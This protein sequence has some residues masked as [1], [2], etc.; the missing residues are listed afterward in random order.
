MQRCVGPLARLGEN[1]L[2]AITARM[3]FNGLSVS[4][5]LTWSALP[6]RVVPRAPARHYPRPRVTRCGQGLCERPPGLPEMPNASDAGN[7]A[8]GVPG[9]RR[10]LAS[11]PDHPIVWLRQ[12]PRRSHAGDTAG[13]DCP[14]GAGALADSGALH[15]QGHESGALRLCSRPEPGKLDPHTADRTEQHGAR[16]QLWTGRADPCPGVE[17]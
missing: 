17:L 4:V 13:I 2:K 15:V 5:S 14:G 12:L 3:S 10:Y 6:E 16:C 8:H 7:P 1:S 9:L 11:G